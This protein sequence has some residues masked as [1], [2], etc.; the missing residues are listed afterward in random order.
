MIWSYLTGGIPQPGAPIRLD[1]GPGRWALP[2]LVALVTAAL[3]IASALG[4]GERPRPVAQP[5]TS[6]EVSR[7]LADDGATRSLGAPSEPSRAR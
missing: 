4:G 2:L 6:T 5:L 7:A 1:L 3:L